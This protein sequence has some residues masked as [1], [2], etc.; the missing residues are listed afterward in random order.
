VLFVTVI[1]QK[2]AYKVWIE[3]DRVHCRS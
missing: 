1:V 3:A 2:D